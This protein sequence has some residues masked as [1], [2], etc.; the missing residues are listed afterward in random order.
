MSSRRA[1][2][3][4]PLLLLMVEALD[5]R[6]DKDRPDEGKALRELGALAR[7]KVPARGVLAPTEDELYNAIDQIAMR[8]L[9]LGVP[10]KA[11]GA[12]LLGV[13]PFA[14]RD[15]IEVAVNH[16]CA[17]LDVA[18]FNAGLAFGVTLAE[19]RWNH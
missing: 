9:S 19:F 7:I 2:G 17:V 8:H 1:G 10:R 3:L 5:A 13:E 6:H 12:A 18:Y 14:K 11:L 15:E 4:S 16:L